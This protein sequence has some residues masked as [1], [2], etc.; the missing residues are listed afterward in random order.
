MNWDAISAGGEIVGALAVVV[1][2]LYVAVQ[3]RHNTKTSQDEAY[4]DIF[5]QINCQ[6]HAMAEPSN[7]ELI[8]KGL[9]DYKGLEGKDKFRFA[10]LMSALITNLE[11]S[12][13]SSDAEL[14]ID[15]TLKTFADWLG[16]RYFA[17]PGMLEWWEE[18]KNHFDPKARD[19]VDAQILEADVESDIWGIK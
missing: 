7:A 16:P 3:I 11:L 18:S 8:L 2:L 9:I 5:G 4:R 10:C 1:S 17:Y 15:D 12:V 6:F 13:F 19:W 14:M